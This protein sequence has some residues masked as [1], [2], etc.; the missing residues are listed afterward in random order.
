[1][2]SSH[3]IVSSSRTV[4]RM[5]EV[6]KS[7][8]QDL[9]ANPLWTVNSRNDGIQSRRLSWLQAPEGSSKLLWPKWVRDTV[10]LRCWDLPQVGQL[11]VDNPERLVSPGPVYHIL[12][13]MRGNG[14]CRDM[15]Q[16][17]GASRLA[18]EFLDRAPRLAAM[19]E[20]SMELTAYSIT[21]VLAKK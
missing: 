13:K 8:N 17:R 2:L 6:R 12:H 15:V 3:S 20:K 10:T 18:S 19:C 4:R 7:Q 21:P 16:A 5:Q 14:V 1:M 9:I 11:L